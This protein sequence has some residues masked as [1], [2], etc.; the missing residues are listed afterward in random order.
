VFTDVWDRE[1]FVAWTQSMLESGQIEASEPYQGAIPPDQL[2]LQFVPF[3]QGMLYVGSAAPL[4]E[5]EV[6]L[7]RTLADAF[8]V[9]YARY[10]DFQQLELQNQALEVAKTRVED[11]LQEVQ[12]TQT[13]LVQSEKMASLGQM[14]AG[15]AHEIKNPLNFVNNFAELNTELTDEIFD[16]L[17]ADPDLRVSAVRDVLDDIRANASQINKHGK[18]ADAIVKSMMQHARGDSGQRMPVGVNS[19]VEEYVNLAFHG[20]RAS[21]PGFAAEVERDYDE[22]AG[23]VEMMGQALGRV[24][25]NLLSNAFYAVLKRADQESNAYVPTVSV[26]TR[27]TGGRILIQVS[28]NGTGMPPDVREKIFNPF[29]TT[30]PTGEG[31]GLG[32][33]LSYDIITQGHGGQLTVESTEG[34]GTTFTI[35]LPL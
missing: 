13:Q 22:H 11:A 20:M 3:T 15:I 9:A 25:L 29:F 8:A 10:E 28:D 32:L 1:R 5:A 17:A 23:T 14:T 24:V 16:E 2:A 27:R 26:S 12:Q 34:E 30:K 7:V 6:G 4:R 31:T 19:M 35:A 33:S 21:T 18:R